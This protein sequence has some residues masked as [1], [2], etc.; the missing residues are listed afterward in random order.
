MTHSTGIEPLDRKLEGG[1]HPGSIVAIVTPPE[2]QVEPLLCAS[3]DHRPT[4]YY[5]TVQ[6]ADGLRRQL[7][8][9]ADEPQ[10]ERLEHVGIDGALPKILDHVGDLGTEHD[11][12]VDVMDPLENHC[13]MERYANFLNELSQTLIDTDSIAFLACLDSGNEPDNRE[14]TLTVADYVLELIPEHEGKQLSYYLAVPKATGV[15]L[16]D[17]E[18]IFKLDLGEDVRIDRSRDI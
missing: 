12:V 9:L 16:T 14:F 6:T 13:G 8:R 1:I 2:A 10:L 17:R 4:Q 11:V 5:T 7:N 18:R 3:I 15:L